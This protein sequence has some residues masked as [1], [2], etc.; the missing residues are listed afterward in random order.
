MGGHSGRPAEAPTSI[1]SPTT[2]LPIRIARAAAVK[3]QASAP[4]G[5]VCLGYATASRGTSSP[6]PSGKGGGSGRSAQAGTQTSAGTTTTLRA[7]TA[8]FNSAS[9]GAA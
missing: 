8:T 7:E 9:S 3:P 4:A 1:S 5:L 6:K 2:A